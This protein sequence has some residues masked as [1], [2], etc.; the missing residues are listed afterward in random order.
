MNN[1]LNKIEARLLSMKD[2]AYRDFN[3]SL[4]PT[5]DKSKVIGVRM[6]SVRAYA[7]ELW[8]DREA[9]MAFLSVLPHKYH[10][11][12]LLHGALIEKI[13][14]FETCISETERFLPFI[15]NWAVC[16]M[17]HPRVF[18]KNKE[19]LMP[20]VYKWLASDKPYTVRFGI[21][22]MMVYFLDEAFAP[23]QAK[24]ISEIKSEHYYVKM[25]VAW[26]FATALAKQE[27]ETIAY[28][29]PGV[30]D[31]EIRKMAIRKARDSFRISKK[32][33]NSLL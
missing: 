12:N 18:N 19:L 2:E 17:L 27:S 32:L 7:K 31:E 8:A 10:E 25:A 28:F 6:P 26:Y 24:R 5:V 1:S 13:S 9:A 30:L 15:D 14:D 22:M 21:V 33:K 4:I 3:S 16:D 23:E 20:Y 29:A 11:E